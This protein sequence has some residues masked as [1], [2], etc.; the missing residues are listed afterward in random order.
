M[1]KLPELPTEDEPLPNEISP[2]DP[3]ASDVPRVRLPPDP[4]LTV[5]EP[6]SMHTLPPPDPPSPL[7]THTS[8][9][10]PEDTRTVPP[11][12][13]VPQP[14]H[15]LMPPP[16]PV[17]IRI[18]PLPVSS[19]VDDPEEIA[20]SPLEVASAEL[21]VTWP[22]IAPPAPLLTVRL[23]PSHPGPASPPHTCTCPPAPEVLLPPVNAKWPPS[24]HPAL[25]VVSPAPWKPA[26]AI[27]DTQ[28]DIPDSDVPEHI[29][30]KP[31]SSPTALPLPTQTL[32]LRL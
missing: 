10:S 11:T 20:T 30:S 8:P 27:T 6:P 7:D 14:A 29:R 12:S 22:L 16:V 31:E 28:P 15:T 23:P 32:P 25:T 21:M 4:V 3:D 9:P 17:H 19:P 26:P 18:A 2:V 1:H 24:P 5:T 13:L